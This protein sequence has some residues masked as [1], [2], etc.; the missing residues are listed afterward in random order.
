M[1]T[2]L[3]LWSQRD[4]S[5][6]ARALIVNILGAGRFWHVAK[7]LPPPGWVVQRHNK[8]VW[9]FIWKGKMESVSCQRCCAPVDRGG[10]TSLISKCLSL[11]LS[12]LASLGHF[13]ARYFLSLIVSLNLTHAFPFILLVHRRPRNRLVFIGFALQPSR[14]CTRNTL[15]CPTIFPV[16]IFTVYSLIHPRPHRSAL[17]FGWH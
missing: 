12:T 7:V 16:R 15:P 10:S 13:L 9:P 11:R 8:I 6:L 3:N 17:V 5:F 2:L 1:E 14:I 4:L